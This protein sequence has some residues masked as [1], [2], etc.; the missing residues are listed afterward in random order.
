M[1]KRKRGLPEGW[2]PDGYTSVERLIGQWTADN[3]N[4]KEGI[5]AIIPHAGWTFSGRLSALGL[6]ALRDDLDCLVVAGGHLAP[7]DVFRLAEEDF[8]SVPGGSLPGH[9]KLL[10]FLSERL[11]WRPDGAGDNTVEIQLPMVRYFWGE[12][13]VLWIRVPPDAQALELGEL[14]YEWTG[15]SGEK[16]GIAGS[17]DLTHYGPS[18]GFLSRGTG[19]AA[20]D[21]VLEE[22]DGDVVRAMVSGESQRVLE[23]AA[24][25]RAACSA[26]GAAAAMEFARLNGRKQGKLLGYASSY[27]IHPSDSFVG[28]ASI[29]F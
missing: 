5:A 9:R 3:Q 10:D 1:S 28:Y 16:L 26:G 24:D 11:P 7:G 12:L 29:V 27:D 17:T 21:W 14:L 15:L 13:P 18:Y 19:K 22:N 8:F 20:R 2:Y 4:G 6:S 25:T 23:L